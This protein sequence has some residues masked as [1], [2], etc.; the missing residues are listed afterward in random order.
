MFLTR[1]TDG[2]NRRSGRRAA[3][4][5]LFPTASRVTAEL[6]PVERVVRFAPLT[7]DTPEIN[8][9]YRRP[10]TLDPD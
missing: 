7:Y 3:C 1:L 2:A 8:P 4:L 10:Q 5:E 6:R 9:L